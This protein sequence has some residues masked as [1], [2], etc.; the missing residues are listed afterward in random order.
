MGT[1]VVR[2][3]P[4][5]DGQG[6]VSDTASRIANLSLPGRSAW[7]PPP[8]RAPPWRQPAWPAMAGRSACTGAYGLDM[9][10]YGNGYSGLQRLHTLPIGAV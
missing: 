7:L 8:L 10:D 2:L 3:R 4:D 1:P 6:L 9:D 5:A